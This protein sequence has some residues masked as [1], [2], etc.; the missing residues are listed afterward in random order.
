MPPADPAR[1]ADLPGPGDTRPA[2]RGERLL[3]LTD[4]QLRQGVEL[5]FFAYR[6]FTGDPDRILE[7]FGYGRAH[8]RAMHFIHSRPGL[9]VQGLLDILA[10]TKQSLNRVLRQLVEDGIV[11]SEPGAEDRRQRVLR[12]TRTGAEL[13]ARLAEAQ[14]AR[15]RRAYAEA[16]PDAVAGFRRVLE[17]MIDERR[18]DQV[19]SLVERRR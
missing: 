5:M 11:A 4:A 7:E 2:P 6:D 10:V 17:A 9:T 18:R 3:Y 14:Q 13:E 1:E 16:G 8:H 19:L 15:M 12:L